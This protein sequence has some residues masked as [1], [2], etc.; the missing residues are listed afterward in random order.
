MFYFQINMADDGKLKFKVPETDQP[1]K[2][3][4]LEVKKDVIPKGFMVHI[5]KLGFRDSDAK[6]L[7]ENKDDWI[8]VSTGEL[9][10]HYSLLQ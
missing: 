6:V 2:S 8:G 9:R 7:Y 4:K 5:R 1:K 3:R 10:L